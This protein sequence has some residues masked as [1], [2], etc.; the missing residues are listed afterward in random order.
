MAAEDPFDRFDEPDFAPDDTTPRRRPDWLVGADE[1]VEAER[2]RGQETGEP[3]FELRRPDI[4]ALP[5]RPS[6]EAPPPP[7]PIP[8]TGAASSVP[9][10]R[11]V[12]STPTPRAARESGEDDPPEQ[13]GEV[14]PTSGFLDTPQGPARPAPALRAVPRPAPAREAAWVVWLDLLATDR[15]LQ[16]VVGAVVLLVLV[17][18]FWPRTGGGVAIS[19]IKHH[20][21]AYEG[22]PVRVSGRI[23]EVFVIG[24]GYVFN[25]HQGRDTLVVF[26]RLRYPRSRENTTVVGSVSTGYLDGAARVAVFETEA[27]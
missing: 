14:A 17:L 10:L 23:G 19:A 26:T 3:S 8:W 2:G 24:Q 27:P 11:E 6:R 13:E 4:T 20:P 18:I 22:R 25:L 21:A 9:R 16:A 5:Q 15:R 1:G 12:T 7:K